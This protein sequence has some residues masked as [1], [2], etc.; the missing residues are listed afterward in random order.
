[1][2]LHVVYRSCG[3]ENRKDRPPY[4]SKLLCLVSFLRALEAVD[5]DVVFVNDGPVPADRLRLMRAAGEVVQLPGVGMRGSYRS[6]LDLATS[7]RFDR[8]DVVWFSEDDYLYVP[9]ALEGLLAAAAAVPEADYFALYAT[10]RPLPL[11]TPDG[12]PTPHRPA[13]W[14]DVPPWLVGEQQWTR[15]RST[16]ST[17]GARVGALTED[18]GIFRLCMLPHRTRLRDHD[19]CLVLQ[20]FEPYSYRRLGRDAVGLAS[21]T[22][23]QRAQSA[24]MAPFLL[25]TNLRALR[26]PARRRL[27]LAARPNL[28]CHLE[29]ARL[30]PGTD[31]GAVAGQTL[32]W[33]R[34]RGLLDLAGAE[35]AGGAPRV[36]RA[37]GTPPPPRASGRRRRTAASGSPASS[38]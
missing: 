20:G 3:G 13:G 16:T 38:G 34:Q 12:R 6:S 26:R 32:A 10:I 23:R 21:G 17:F 8:R 9:G 29:S 36:T 11:T 18:A 5:A 24:A 15:I 4:Y 1:M 27:M 31:W 19:T 33:G 35:P 14:W 25:A 22:A 37:P 30:A 28:A 7:G 2:A